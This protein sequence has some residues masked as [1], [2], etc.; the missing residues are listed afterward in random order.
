MPNPLPNVIILDSTKLKAVADDKL[1][2]VHMAISIF[3]QN[4]KKKKK[5]GKRRKC[6]LSAFSTFP[7]V[8]LTH[9]SID[10]RFN[11]STKDSF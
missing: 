4:K 2:R 9:Y 7:K 10:T 5:S 8:F 1:N 3:D 6:W 11:A